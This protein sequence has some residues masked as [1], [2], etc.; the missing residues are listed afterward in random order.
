MWPK[1]GFRDH[2]P[3]LVLSSTGLH[4]LRLPWFTGK[5]GALSF[6]GVCYSSGIKYSAHLSSCIQLACMGWQNNSFTNI[7]VTC[8]YDD[9]FGT[10]N[11]FVTSNVSYWMGLNMIQYFLCS[12]NMNWQW[13]HHSTPF[14]ICVHYPTVATATTAHKQPLTFLINWIIM[15]SIQ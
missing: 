10:F 6:C 5:K 2:S 3:S 11:C 8:V 9:I 14:D 15:N 12:L 4:S 13:K 1:V 7:F